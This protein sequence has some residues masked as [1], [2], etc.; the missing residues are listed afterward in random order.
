MKKMFVCLALLVAGCGGSEAPAP[1]SVQTPTPPPVQ[2]IQPVRTDIV[3]I[4]DSLI[5]H[6][7][8]PAD[9]VNAGI[10]GQR[11][12]EMLARFETDVLAHRPTVVV[13]EGGVN[14][15]VGLDNPGARYIEDMARMASASGA[16]VI[17]IGILPAVLPSWC[18]P[19]SDFNRDIRN[20]ALANGYTYVDFTPILTNADGT[21]RTELYFGDLLHVTDAAYVLMWPV[22]EKALH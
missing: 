15:I 12:P 14:D 6:W 18:I 16:R 5:A 4:G 3:F 7:K 22:M 19:I 17:L 2:N 13:I 9:I 20:V 21:L 10:G 8:L 1:V 11:T